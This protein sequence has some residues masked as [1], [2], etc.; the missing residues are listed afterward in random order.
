M[1]AFAA[2]VEQVRRVRTTLD[3]LT[4]FLDGLNTT[5]GGFQPLSVC[6][7]R[8]VELADCDSCIVPRVLCSN[9]CGALAKACY[10]PFYDTFND[11]FRR[12]WPIVQ[13]TFNSLP[14]LWRRLNDNRRVIDIN[15][16]QFVSFLAINSL[17]IFVPHIVCIYVVP[18]PSIIILLYTVY[19]HA[20]IFAGD[21]IT[22]V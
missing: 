22:T 9:W 18:P 13:R 15:F 6:V 7:N 4:G 10:S 16:G 5:L 17:T 19:S 8:L 11:Q 3:K 2:A 12:F 14:G 21:N 20:C 1:T